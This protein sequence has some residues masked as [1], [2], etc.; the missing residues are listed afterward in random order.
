M[1]LNTLVALTIIAS[2]SLF[3]GCAS[4][5]RQDTN[6]FPSPKPDQGLVYFYRESKLLG[7]AVSYNVKEG[8]KVI[9]ALAHGTYFFVFADPGKHTYSA[10]TEAT[11]SR[12]LDVEAGKTY[13]IEASVEMGVLAGHPS[14]KIASD[15]EAKS[16]LPTLTYA[17]K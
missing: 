10:T 17:I 8:D 5:T 7:M 16:V 15:A 14:L 2:S 1:K 9:G 11:S 13:Y 3:S 12:T 6:V 4:V